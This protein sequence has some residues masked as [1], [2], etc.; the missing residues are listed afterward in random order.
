MKTQTKSNALEHLKR[1][2]EFRNYSVSTVET[3]GSLM[4]R[5]VKTSHLPLE[6]ITLSQFKDYLHKVVIEKGL[7]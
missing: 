2:L 3:Y 7:S 1:E 6:S 5:M 4:S